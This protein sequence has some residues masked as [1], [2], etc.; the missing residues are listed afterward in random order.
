MSTSQQTS[1]QILDTLDRFARAWSR[2]DLDGLLSLADP[3]ITGFLPRTTRRIQGSDRFSRSVS[4]MCSGSGG[5]ILRFH[6]P[7]VVAI[8]TVAWVSSG[9]SLE[10]GEGDMTS[11]ENGR[12]TAVLK[13]TGHSWLFSQFHFSLP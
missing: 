9:Y 10:K 13:G 3:E 6:D 4:E 12:F 7:L 2:K 1:L 8:G 5:S 11:R